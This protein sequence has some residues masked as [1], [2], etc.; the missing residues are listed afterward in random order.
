[1][2]RRVLDFNLCELLNGVRPEAQDRESPAVL[3]QQQADLI[4]V[5]VGVQ[6]FV[7]LL[8]LHLIL[9]GFPALPRVA[10]LRGARL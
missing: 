7:V 5:R 6:G 4:V 1:M 8:V 10:C 9:R 2:C 3:P